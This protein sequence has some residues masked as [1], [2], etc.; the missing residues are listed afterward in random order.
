MQKVLASL[1][2]LL[3]AVHTARICRVL[4][5]FEAKFYRQVRL[6]MMF[7][8]ADERAVAMTSTPPIV[9]ISQCLGFFAH[10]AIVLREAEEGVLSMDYLLT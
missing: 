5:E 2:T 7:F 1:Q 3:A 8:A 10:A 6:H 9:G 4:G